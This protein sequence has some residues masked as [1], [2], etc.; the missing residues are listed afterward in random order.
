MTRRD[1]R[2]T[3]SNPHNDYIRGTLLECGGVRC[4]RSLIL[5][6]PSYLRQ[7][8]H[9]VTNYENKQVQRS[10]NAMNFLGTWAFRS[11][12]SAIPYPAHRPRPE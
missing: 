2:V 3:V 6:S 12:C 9:P 7:D 8:L 4:T 11:P 1:R 10:T 5:C